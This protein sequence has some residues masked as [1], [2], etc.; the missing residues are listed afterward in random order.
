M[1]MSFGQFD[2]DNALQNVSQVHLPVWSF[3]SMFFSHF[4]N[5][6][7]HLEMDSIYCLPFF[8]GITALIKD[9]G[10]VLL[11]AILTNC[12]CGYSGPTSIICLGSHE[13]LVSKSDCGMKRVL[14]KFKLHGLGPKGARSHQYWDPLQ[15][16]G[17]VVPFTLLWVGASKHPCLFHPW[18]LLRALAGG[19]HPCLVSWTFPDKGLHGTTRGQTSSTYHRTP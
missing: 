11:L 7:Q 10:V 18:T 17:V 9:R 3:E 4:C 14:L 1:S 5:L 12:P 8:C 6:L 16:V 15:L 19:H 13:L 2:F